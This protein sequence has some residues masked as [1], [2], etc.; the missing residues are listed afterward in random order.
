MPINA[1]NSQTLPN[2]RYFKL[3]GK[4]KCVHWT[5][6]EKVEI[7]QEMQKNQIGPR[8]MGRLKGIPHSTIVSWRKQGIQHFMGISDAKMKTK[9]QKSLLYDEELATYV[10]DL[11]R[12]GSPLNRQEIIA[13]LHKN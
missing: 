9:K 4:R 3:E 12:A 8:E 2:T 10:K 6:Q 11:H 13:L 1:E 5:D 7:L